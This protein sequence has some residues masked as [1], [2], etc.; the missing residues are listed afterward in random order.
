VPSAPG[1]LAPLAIVA[2]LAA[3]CGGSGTSG[4]PSQERPE[5]L[6]PGGTLVAF[7]DA[8]SAGDEAAAR[9]FL[10]SPSRA[11]LDLSGLRAATAPVTGGRVI[12][13]QLVDGPWAVAAVV[14]GTHAYAA[15]LRR[16]GGYWRVE[17]GD[18]IRLRP[19]LPHP[20]RLAL[21]ADPQIAAEARAGKDV[22]LALWLDG[23]DFAV[24]GGGP[25]PGFI[26][27]FGRVGSELS[28]GVHVVV[29]FARAGRAAAATAWTFRVGEP[30]G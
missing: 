4:P 12:I 10:T 11:G 23:S 6:D 3:G 29:A 5:A 20:G 18:P 28:P 7:V 27:A 13:S 24:E 9:S 26:T 1:R 15:A 19:I 30:V 17:L 21:S 22:R 14:K 16:V 2:A 25:R 8:A